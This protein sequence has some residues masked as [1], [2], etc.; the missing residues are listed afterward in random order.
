MRESLYDVLI[1]FK[2]IINKNNMENCFRILKVVYFRLLF[3][4][5]L[6]VFFLVIFRIKGD[7]KREIF[8]L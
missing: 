6:F 5:C 8:I 4:Y 3:E 7:L 2:D 1:N